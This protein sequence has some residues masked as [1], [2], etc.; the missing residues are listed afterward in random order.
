[1]PKT[2]KEVLLLTADNSIQY[3]LR[4]IRPAFK[5]AALLLLFT[6]I[7][8]III[9]DVMVFILRTLDLFKFGYRDYYM[10]VDTVS[11]KDL[12]LYTLDVKRKVWDYVYVLNSIFLGIY[13]LETNYT[14]NDQ[15]TSL[16]Q[17]DILDEQ[18]ISARL[19][20]GELWKSMSRVRYLH[21][22]IVVYGVLNFI[23][24]LVVLDW[25]YDWSP[26][27]KNLYEWGD[28]IILFA[29]LV[30]LYW[31]W[32]QKTRLRNGQVPFVWGSLRHTPPGAVVAGLVVLWLLPSLGR[33]LIY[34]L[35]NLMVMPL[36]WV[37]EDRLY[38]IAWS[39]LVTLCLLPF[40]IIFVAIF[41]SQ[42]IA[43]IDDENPE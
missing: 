27:F 6:I 11:F 4:L 36:E 19:S 14:N 10:L 5:I 38:I 41:Y 43:N 23:F 7:E 33:Q 2:L 16:P 35:D 25:L 13:W 22:W 18:E 3:Y 12:I 39:M 17:D 9:N 28:F 34:Q 1:M 37:V 32:Y 24:N 31:K 29:F 30:F 42:L 40:W 8:S 26:L 20:A 15:A 21:I